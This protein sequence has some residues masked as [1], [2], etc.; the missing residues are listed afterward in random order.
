[1]YWMADFLCIYLGS[2]DDCYVDTG[3]DMYGYILTTG[4]T[5]QNPSHFR[6]GVLP[7]FSTC[8]RPLSL[9]APTTSP[10]LGIFPSVAGTIPYHI[11]HT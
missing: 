4:R 1:M 9:L 2:E 5:G 10:P 8:R 3:W 7:P 6:R 11:L